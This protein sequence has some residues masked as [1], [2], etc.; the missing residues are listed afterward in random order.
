MIAKG[1]KTRWWLIGG[2][3]VIVITLL[4]VF[5]LGTS[6]SQ[7][8][9]ISK[10]VAVNQALL[11]SK[12][13]GLFGGSVSEPSKIQGEL[14]TFDQARLFVFGKSIGPDEVDAKLRDYPVWLIVLEGKFVEH[15]PSAPDIPA[16]DVLHSQM[17]IIL[18]ANTAEVMEKYLISPDQKLSTVSLPVLSKPSGATLTI[19][20]KL[21][22][23]TTIPLPTVS[24]K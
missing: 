1:N 11:A 21:P 9:A 15:V 14:I 8:S 23:S 6:V 10:D 4:T 3:S 7:T 18:D 17:A 20:T 19:P 13:N 12:D 2:L 22:I 5:A 16:K 24:L